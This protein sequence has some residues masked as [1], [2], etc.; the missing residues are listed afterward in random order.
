MS[1]IYCV[2]ST[3]NNLQ[4]RDEHNNT[5]KSEELKYYEEKLELF[6]N[7]YLNMMSI[8]LSLRKISSIGG[9]MQE[10]Y[11]ILQE[12]KTL[13]VRLVRRISLETQR[14]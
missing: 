4:L 10:L 14:Q 13:T 3:I 5:E 11:E 6:K 8:K 12:I 9:N 1:Y 2:N 7:T